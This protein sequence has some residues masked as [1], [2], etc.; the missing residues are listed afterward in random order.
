[1]ILSFFYRF[2]IFFIFSKHG[3]IPSAVGATQVQARIGWG[4]FMDQRALDGRVI[5]LLSTVRHFIYQFSFK[6]NNLTNSRFDNF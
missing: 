5:A 2:F 6:N 3:R 4:R 1:M